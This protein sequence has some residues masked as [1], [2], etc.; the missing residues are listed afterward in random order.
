MT[1]SAA[2]APASDA[3][4]HVVELDAEAYRAAIP[5]LAELIVD[6][7]DGGSSVNFLAGVT[8]AEAAAWWEARVESV[9][10]GQTTAFVATSARR[11]LGS[12]LLIRATQANAP[13]RAEIA[14]VLV[15][16]DARRQDSVA[17]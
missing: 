2:S 13:H 15:H 7:V 6:V 10:G 12:A 9:A 14:K 17:G 1:D 3:P 16:R 4:A 5:G 11:I 8:P